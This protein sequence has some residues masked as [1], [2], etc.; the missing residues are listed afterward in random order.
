ILCSGAVGEETAVEMMRRGAQDFVMKDRLR[1]LSAVVERALR[2]AQTRRDKKESDRAVEELFRHF[3]ATFDFAAVGILHMSLD[4]ELLRVNPYF[5]RMMQ[6]DAQEMRGVHF[7]DLVHAADWPNL[8]ERY[9]ALIRGEVESVH[10][11]SRYMRANGEVLHARVSSTIYHDREGAPL[12]ILTFVTDITEGVRNEEQI[13][14]QARLLDLVKQAVIATD[15]GGRVTYWNQ[16]A[17]ELYGW[18]KNEAIGRHIVQVSTA[19][20]DTKRAATILAE[21][22]ERGA[23]AGEYP[24]TPKNGQTFPAFIRTQAMYDERGDLSGMLA[25][26][27]DMTAQKTYEQ[28][29]LTRA[30]Q[31]EA[32]AELGR[33]ALAA[34]DPRAFFQEATRVAAELLDGELSSALECDPATGELVVRAV[35]GFDEEVIGRHIPLNSQ[36]GY[37]LETR[38]GIISNNHEHETRFATSAELLQRGVIASMTSVIRAATGDYGV[39]SVHAREPRSWTEQDLAFLNSLANVVGTAIERTRAEAVLHEQSEAIRAIV[40]GSPDLIMRID[41]T[42]RV[43]Y[44]N[45]AGGRFTGRDTSD[46]LG[47]TIE[48]FAVGADRAKLYRDALDEVVTS[49]REVEFSVNFTRPHGTLW[50]HVRALPQFDRDGQLS[51]VMCV[52]MDITA[53]RQ[54]MEE[55]T[56]SRAMLEEAQEIAAIGSWSEELESG[57]LLWSDQT[58]QIFGVEPG[59]PITNTL[60]L[61]FVHPDDHAA[62]DR[63][64]RQIGE[65]SDVEEL[66]Y[67]I[68]RADGCERIIHERA[69]GLRSEGKLTGLIGTCQDIT[70]R[71]AAEQA[72]RDSEQQYRSLVEL[73]KDAIFKMD[74]EGRFTMVNDAAT[75]L[76]GWSKE[77]LIGRKYVELMHPEDRERASIV[78][79]GA[80]LG[81]E[82]VASEYRFLMKSG[83]W[84]DIESTGAPDIRD[85]KVIG[86]FGIARD[87]TDRRKT[88]RERALMQA[89]LERAERLSSLGRMAA[90]IAHEFNNVLMG[91]GPFAEVIQR[92]ASDP[93]LVA[94]SRRILASVH[95]GKNITQEVLRFTRPAEPLVGDID[96]RQ[97]LGELHGELRALLPSSIQLEFRPAATP[98]RIQGDRQQLDQVIMNLAKNAAEAMPGEGRLIVEMTEHQPGQR[99]EWGVIPPDQPMVHVTIKD[100]G[101]G[102]EPELLPKLFEPF[103]TTK[104]NGTGLGLPIAHQIIK[105]HGGYIFAESE[106]GVGTAFHLLLPHAAPAAATPALTT[107][108]P[109]SRRAPECVLLVE[110]DEAVADGLIALLES[111]GIQ[112]KWVSTGEDA[113]P[114]V[115]AIKPSLVVLDVGLPGISG[116]EVWSL[117][118]DRNPELP[119]I[120]ST[121]HAEEEKLAEFLVEKT[122]QFLRKPY[123][124]DDLIGAWMRMCA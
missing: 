36:S 33:V 23:W 6:Y 18:P 99:Y 70:E 76:T 9:E 24:L 3:Q 94:A 122:T 90:S 48:E 51:S 105:K 32:V 112:V 39:L 45:A 110:D 1:K 123:V 68:R 42:G 2:E 124:A 8:R 29:L 85:G 96:A 98:L 37:T 49:G 100:T 19:P 59:T 40:E 71:R 88:E 52:G 79:G 16:F 103:Y 120:F 28:E 47:K 60:F 77:E 13:A 57:L 50:M 82:S 11:N 115:E 80:L 5:C 25:V 113:L 53:R 116:V 46:Y 7:R 69:R 63:V 58:Y 74:L 121:G 93:A 55:L 66:E 86:L 34:R 107:A 73:A 44:V 30:K 54:Q 61:S 118:R 10:F 35:Y 78:F 111:E 65:G 4:I 38:S 12:Y 81:G 114:A 117:L 95:R 97:W 75:V 56:R 62:I 22:A 84:L 15:A 119:V 14:Y 17:E 31:Q 109:S 102:I 27:L 108:K 106:R 72:L 41:T 91:I 92:K 67:R 87:L 20:Q 21:I 26:A 43:L 64:W 83:E 101:E 89:E 104:R